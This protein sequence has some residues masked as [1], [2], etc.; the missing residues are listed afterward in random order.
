MFLWNILDESS[1]TQGQTLSVSSQMWAVTTSHLITS[2]CE[3]AE[4]RSCFDPAWLRLKISKT[5]LYSWLRNLTKSFCV[6]Y[7]QKHKTTCAM[8]YVH[9]RSLR[10][11]KQVPVF[12]FRRVLEEGWKHCDSAANRR[13]TTEDAFLTEKCDKQRKDV[14]KW[15]VSHF[16]R[17]IHPNAECNY[18]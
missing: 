14:D 7:V 4:W 6:Q 18:I 1:Q 12:S 9:S 5:S 16:I 2:S 17:S 11:Q 10:W 13:Q 3:R 15:T 8:F